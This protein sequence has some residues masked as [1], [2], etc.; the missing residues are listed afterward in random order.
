VI[1]PC[2][3]TTDLVGQRSLL[4]GFERARASCVTLYIKP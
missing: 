2:G 3:T 4:P 1:S